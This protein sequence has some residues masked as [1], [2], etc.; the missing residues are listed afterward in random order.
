MDA[1]TTSA[2]RSAQGTTQYKPRVRSSLKTAQKPQVEQALQDAVK[3]PGPA[4]IV[5]LK[6]PRRTIA[7]STAENKAQDTKIS[8]PVAKSLNWTDS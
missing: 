3:T 8:Q 4:P 1:L 7:S 2:G 5:Q 6:A